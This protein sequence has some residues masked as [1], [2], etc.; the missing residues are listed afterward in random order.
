MQ[1]LFGDQL[2]DR[3]V[4][5]TTAAAFSE[6]ADV[7][8]TV[9]HVMQRI[10]QWAR[11]GVFDDSETSRFDALDRELM[12]QLAEVRAEV[13]AANERYHQE[14]GTAPLQESRGRRAL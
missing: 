8:V 6:I 9:G 10:A 14:R 4:S 3:A 2:L 13:H 11:D 1:E 12:R 5:G 7:A